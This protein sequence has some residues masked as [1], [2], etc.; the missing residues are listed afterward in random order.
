MTDIAV[1][2]EFVE[3]AIKEN[4]YNN[5]KYNNVDICPGVNMVYL[6][7][8]SIGAILLYRIVSAYSIYRLTNDIKR[9]FSQ[10]LD[11][12]L[13]RTMYVNYVNESIDPCNPKDGY[14]D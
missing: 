5:D 8:L 4:K 1:C 9:I 2:V 13:F 10:L 12:E 7:L 6:S 3:L 11:F 14:T